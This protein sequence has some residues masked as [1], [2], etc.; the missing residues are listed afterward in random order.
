MRQ[1]I[2]ILLFIYCDSNFCAFFGLF[3]MGFVGVSENWKTAKLPYDFGIPKHENPR[4]PGP[5]RFR[6]FE[7]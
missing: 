4:P 1:H 6:Q 5:P 3:G 2:A 7:N